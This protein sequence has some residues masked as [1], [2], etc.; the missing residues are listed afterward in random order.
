MDPKDSLFRTQLLREQNGLTPDVPSRPIEKRAQSCSPSPRPIRLTP[1]GQFVSH[2]SERTTQQ[3]CCLFP[4]DFS[5]AQ[6]VRLVKSSTADYATS[7]IYIY[8]M[9]DQGPPVDAQCPS[10]AVALGYMGVASAVCL[11]NWGSAVSAERLSDSCLAVSL[12]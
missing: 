4:S 7:N 10:Y 2:T 12:S 6:L 9:V 1:C 11:S 8:I 3:H 5:E